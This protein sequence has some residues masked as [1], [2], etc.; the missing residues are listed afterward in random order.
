MFGRA[1]PAPAEPSPAPAPG[2]SPGP[3]AP[4]PSA[5]PQLAAIEA[6]KR[7]LWQA[8]NRDE[9]EE[10]IR[11]AKKLL[12]ELPDAQAVARAI[13]F[14]A[15]GRAQLL[16]GHGAA[17]QKSFARSLEL[18]A[19]NVT[20][21]YG[22]FA[23]ALLEKNHELATSRIAKLHEKLGRSPPTQTAHA[24]VIAT[25]NAAGHRV[26]HDKIQKGECFDPVLSR[27]VLAALGK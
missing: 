1:E 13:C 4:A 11:L 22:E 7:A 8:I 14:G 5:N 20:S 10:T 24:L 17:A 15:I 27:H 9:H 19:T 16:Q 6:D 26:A 23:V 21:L 18:D 3:P 25:S 2:A 12:G